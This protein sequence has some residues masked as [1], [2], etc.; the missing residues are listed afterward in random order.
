MFSEASEW[1]P[2]GWTA[3]LE[4]VQQEIVVEGEVVEEWDCGLEGREEMGH[5]V[6][7]AE[8]EGG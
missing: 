1:D 3:E 4:D 6:L 7:V 8:I 2:R 5:C